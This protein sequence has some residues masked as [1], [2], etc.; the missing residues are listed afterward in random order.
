[1]HRTR[2]AV[3]LSAMTLLAGTTLGA[4]PAAADRGSGG[5]TKRVEV[6]DDCDPATFNAALGPGACVGEGETTIEEFSAEFERTGAVDD[7]DFK[8]DDFHIDHGDRIRAVSTGGEFHTFTEV[9]EFGDGCVPDLNGEVSTPVPECR[10]EE[11]FFATA[12][13]PGARL[14]VA[15]LDPGTHRFECLIHP[16][17]RS[18]VEVRGDDDDG[19]D[20]DEHDD[21]AE[22][23]GHSG[24]SG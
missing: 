21:Q 19:D 5:D 12:M 15:G 20:D 16:W 22:H 1:M 4:A 2:L 10:D 17:M 24:H 23:A 11:L 7:W 14:T 18:V 6:R 9:A 13:P 3:V 8:P